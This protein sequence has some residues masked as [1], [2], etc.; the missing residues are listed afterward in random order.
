M[1]KVA[2]DMHAVSSSN[3]NW[4]TAHFVRHLSS[5]EQGLSDNKMWQEK[6]TSA[7]EA[8]ETLACSL[9]SPV[10]FGMLIDRIDHS[11]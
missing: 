4:E 8:C 2:L 11:S 1:H 5:G 9:L 10:F 6:S 3:K 7:P